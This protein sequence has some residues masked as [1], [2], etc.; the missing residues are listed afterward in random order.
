MDDQTLEVYN[1]RAA[2]MAA[3]QRATHAT[4]V[5][6]LMLQHFLPGGPSADIG[7]GSGRDVAWLSEQGF[8]A[9]GYEPSA[10]MRAEAQAAYPNIELHATSLPELEGIPDGVFA[11]VL[12]NAVLMHLPSSALP[13]A[14]ANLARILRPGGR[15]VISYRNSRTVEEREDDGRLFSFIDPVTLHETLRIAGLRQIDAVEELDEARPGIVWRAAAAAKGASVTLDAV[16]IRPTREEDAVAYRALRLEGLRLHPEAFG[17]DYATNE[18]RSLDDW[19][20]TMRQGS[21]GPGGI[22]FVAEHAGMLVGIMRLSLEEAP[23]VR[24][25][26]NIYSVYVTASARG[27]GV[28]EALL[29]ACLAWAETQGVRIVKLSVVATNAAAI[30]LYLR[31]GFSVYGVD[32]EAILWNGIYYDELLMARRI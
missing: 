21:G 20:T 28:A 11:N 2:T 18:A 31:C 26:A 16:T 15:L 10:G 3:A 32:P 12:C 30:R 27:S 24:H 9:I 17:A 8:A 29:R 7:C 22:N 14:L 4:Q 1:Q 13:V 19:R 5:N 23:K 25:G 6:R